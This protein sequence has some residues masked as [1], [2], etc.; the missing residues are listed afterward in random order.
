M[1]PDDLGKLYGHIST[2]FLEHKNLYGLLLRVKKIIK[3]ANLMTASLILSEAMEKI[4][5]QTIDCLDCDRA[6]VFLLDEVKEELWTKVAKGSNTIRMP[7]TKG[8]V[9]YVVTKGETVNILNAYDDNRFNKEIDR[10]NNYKT[11]TIL[12]APMLDKTNRVVGKNF[13]F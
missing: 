4:V 1:N 2:I 8:V 12:C 10:I 13:F 3:A 6:S 5:D 11:N 7:M 9:G